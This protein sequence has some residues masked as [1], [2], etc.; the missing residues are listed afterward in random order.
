MHNSWPI[1]RKVHGIPQDRYLAAPLFERVDVSLEIEQPENR[2]TS[3]PGGGGERLPAIQRR[4]ET[5][6]HAALNPLN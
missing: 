4:V 6:R 5:S 1:L 3:T 2:K